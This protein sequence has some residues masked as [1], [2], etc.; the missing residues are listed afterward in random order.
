MQL[1]NLA[2]SEPNK[3]YLLILLLL[4]STFQYVNHLRIIWR[5]KK[6]FTQ[7]V[8]SERYNQIEFSDQNIHFSDS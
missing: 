6:T 1:K 7:S 3:N 2:Y 5:N 4:P 8:R